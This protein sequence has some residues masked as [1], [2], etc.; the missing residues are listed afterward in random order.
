MRHGFR[1]ILIYLGIAI[2]LLWPVGDGWVPGGMWTDSWNS[3]WAMWFAHEA[4]SQGEL[5]W[6]THL[7]NHPNGGTVLLPDAL[8]ALFGSLTVGWLGVAGATTA[9]F[10]LQLSLAGLVAHRF[11]IEWM[12]HGGMAERNA[13]TAAWVAGIGHMTAPVL[14]AGAYCGTTEA[15]AGGWTALAVWLHW[16]TLQHPTWKRGILAGVGYWLAALAG[17]YTVTIAFVFGAI[18]SLADGKRLGVSAGWPFLLGLIGVVPFAFVSLQIHGDP[19]HLATRAP[20]VYAYIRNGVGSASIMGMVW[21]IDTPWIGT[22]EGSLQTDGYLHTAYLGWTL[23]IGS[24]VTLKRGIRGSQSLLLAGMLCAILAWGPGPDGYLPYGWIEDLPGFRSLSLLWRLAGGAA[25][26]IAL[27]A[28]AA[29]TGSRTN[30]VFTIVLVLI[31]V[32]VWSPVKGPTPH[33]NGSH[34]GAMVRLESQPPGS[35]LTLPASQQKTDLWLQTQHHHPVTGGINQRRSRAAHAWLDRSKT[36]PWT[37]VIQEAKAIDLRYVIV[38]Q[39]KRLRKGPE[40]AIAHRLQ[41]N[42]KQVSKSERWTVYAVW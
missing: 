25:L 33:V 21:P 39:S 6:T 3:Q 15:V 36:D 30:V 20:E 8:G 14:L 35:V 31:E 9:W 17:W 23:I 37:V 16:R 32:F 27:A 5:P 10:V 40:N 2:A 26:A 22:P 41:Q 19:N 12:V 7:L 42:A 38:H 18:L 13:H 1:L 4:M 28:A 11:A 24:C 29:T 34:Q